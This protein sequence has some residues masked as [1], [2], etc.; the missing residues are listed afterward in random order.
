LVLGEHDVATP[1]LTIAGHTGGYSSR[2]TT[3]AT[4]LSGRLTPVGPLT[5][6]QFNATASFR[7]T[8]TRFGAL[9][10]SR[11]LQRLGMQVEGGALIG[12]AALARGGVEASHIGER[13]DGTV[14]TTESFTPGSPVRTLA[15]VRRGGDHFGSFAELLLFP[16][17]WV[18]I[19]PGLRVDRLPGEHAL[20]MDPRL[21]VELRTGA[22][23]VSLA[24]GV[25]HQ[26]SFRPTRE[27]PG[28]DERTGVARRARHLVLGVEHRGAVTVRADVYT[29][30]YN[31]WVGGTI[32]LR[33]VAGSVIGGDLFLH[34]PGERR[35][36]QVS[37]SI[38]RGRLSLPG[39]EIPSAFDATHSVVAVLKQ[40]VGRVWEV[41][42]TA[43]LATG[44]P[45]TATTDGVIPPDVRLGAPNGDRYPAYQRLDA[46][47]SHYARLGR[48]LLVSY[49]EVLN[50]TGRRN[51]VA[52]GVGEVG[53]E[54][55]PI[56]TF[57]SRRTFVLGA[58]LR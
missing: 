50:V 24:G 7:W 2:G 21:Q 11:R 56:T 19:T 37:Y 36:G 45:F 12:T 53:T 30:H 23:T 15:D 46:R 18:T 44:R 47:L 40:R 32:G 28:L 49:V 39:R 3:I 55:L 34:L 48:G 17:D 33:P 54:P 43:R 27:D 14:P 20:T 4:V 25:F 16:S 10:F 29:K 9:D 6:L 13:L 52:Y 51:V 5:S 26:G 31:R 8:D 1:E 58:E 41:G 35:S 22:F 57:F 42:A 38:L